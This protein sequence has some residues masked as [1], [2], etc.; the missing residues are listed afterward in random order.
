MVKEIDRSELS[1][2]LD[3]INI[4]LWAADQHVC[5]ARRELVG[6]GTLKDYR[7]TLIE[8]NEVQLKFLKLYQKIC[9]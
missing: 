4:D 1:K 3:H 8:Y 9:G 7:A 6:Q 5:K 2:E